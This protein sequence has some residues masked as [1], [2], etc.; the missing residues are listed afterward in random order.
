MEQFFVGRQPILDREFQTVAY[1]LLFR[2]PEGAGDAPVS[3]EEMTA[4]VL[5]G[6]LMDLGLHRLSGNLPVYVKASRG[7]L[8]H[9]MLEEFPPEILGVQLPAGMAA[10]DEVLT[11][12][13]DMRAAG[14]SV[15]L[16]GLPED[17]AWFGVADAVKV[18]MA[19]DGA[20]ETAKEA[21][22]RGLALV[23]GMVETLEQHERAL[24]LGCE[25][26]QG[27]FFCKPQVVEGRKL[28]ESRLA[29]MQAMHRVM[30]AEAIADVEEVILRDVTLSY[31]L[32][33]YINSAAFGMRRKI[34]SVRQ[35]LALLGLANIQ[36]W[37]S[38]MLL[39]AV[40]KD[41][42]RELMRM[43]LLR[44]R[45]LEGLAEQRAPGRK[46][47]YFVLG[48]FSLLDAI[49]GVPMEVALDKLYLP[50]DIHGGLLDRATPRGR[51]LALVEALEQ[52]DWARV[53]ELAAPLGVAMGD[54]VG[55]HTQALLWVNDYMNEML[56]D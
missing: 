46:T 23:A 32:L 24:A 19:D 40:G 9:G 36:Q 44:G 50:E 35:A 27:Y 18:N 33:K 2:R 30:T 10:D 47:D 12:C 7:L 53:D 39:A 6:G 25:R 15:M 1:E 8:L 56:A 11:V 4:H 48:M 34:E 13:R 38:V 16:G 52:D 26:F 20:A 54:L 5:V 43:A 51:E 28:P 41:R 3:D 22:A 14:R 17:A 49:L 45:M 31:R 21:R 29:V 42:P 55:L 37:L